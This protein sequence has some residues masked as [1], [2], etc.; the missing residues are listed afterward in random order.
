MGEGFAV[1]VVV[2]GGELTWSVGVGVEEGIRNGVH[3]ATEG[4]ATWSH[5]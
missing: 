4:A 1:G 5:P 2:E 3:L